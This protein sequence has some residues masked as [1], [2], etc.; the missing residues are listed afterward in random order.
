MIPQ[1][2]IRGLALA[3]ADAYDL[4]VDGQYLRGY[5]RLLAGLERAEAA[6]DRGESWGQDL[7]LLYQEV[8]E[9]YRT[10]YGPDETTEKEQ[11]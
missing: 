1:E 3:A 2:Q 8:I 4:A 5:L 6:R 9:R 7:V 11:E 10:Q